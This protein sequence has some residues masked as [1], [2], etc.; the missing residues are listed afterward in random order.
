[1]NIAMKRAITTLTL[2]LIIVVAFAQSNYDRGFKNGYKEGYCYN[3]FACIAPIAPITPIPNIGESNDN[4][5]DGYNRGFKIGLENKQKSKSSN[6]ENYNSSA[7][8]RRPYMP[9]YV[10]PDFDVLMKMG[11]TLRARFE[12]NKDYRDKIID[13]VFSLKAETSDKDFLNA[14]DKYYKQLRDMDGQ[15]FARLGEQLD[16][17]KQNIKEEIDKC[18]TRAKE[19]PTKLWES[20]NEN[21]RNRNYSQA[22]QDYTK[23]I[24][25][26]PDFADVYRNRGL[27]YQNQ[28]NFSLSLNDL[29]KFIELKSDVSFAYETRGWTKYYL[30]DFMGAIADFNKQIELDPNSPDAYY[31]RGSVKSELNDEY[32]V[33]SDYSK[34]IE[35]KPDFSMAWNNRGWSKFGLKKYSEAL[36]DLNKS[37]ELD[38]SNWVAFDSRQETKFALDDLKGCIEDCTR[39]ISLNPNISNSYFFRGRAYYKQNNKIKA[40]ED[41]SNAG[42]L[43]KSEAYEYITKYCNN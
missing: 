4:Y 19:A 29:N 20:G 12:E 32:G 17:I 5:Q 24:E 40:C 26:R 34:A 6:S 28:R 36:Q 18:N 23:L 41:W 14:M 15:D 9:K 8:N 10:S 1:M 21:M 43:G 2:L 33:I 11:A 27:A 13:W 31:N 7:S 22:I 42:E 35:L 3:D 38:P 39:A 25:L 37:I 30:K 16:I